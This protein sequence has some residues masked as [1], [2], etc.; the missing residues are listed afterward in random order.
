MQVEKDSTTHRANLIEDEINF[1]RGRV[2]SCHLNRFL[3]KNMA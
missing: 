1:A 3:K 2:L